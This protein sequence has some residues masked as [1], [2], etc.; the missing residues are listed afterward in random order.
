MLVKISVL[1]L[2]KIHQTY[3]KKKYF[4]LCNLKKEIYINIYRNKKSLSNDTLSKSINVLVNFF[5][6]YIHQ[7][8]WINK[9][10]TIR[11]KKHLNKNIYNIKYKKNNT[12]IEKKKEYFNIRYSSCRVSP[13]DNFWLLSKYTTSNLLRYYKKNSNKY[14]YKSNNNSFIK[15]YKYNLSKLKYSLSDSSY[16]YNSSNFIRDILNC[17]NFKELTNQCKLYLS[18]PLDYKLNTDTFKKNILYN[19]KSQ[20][21]YLKKKIYN[22]SFFISNIYKK[23]HITIKTYKVINKTIHLIHFYKKVIKTLLILFNYILNFENHFYKWKKKSKESY[24]NYSPYQFKRYN[25]EYSF[26]NKKKTIFYIPEIYKWL[27]YYFSK[28]TKRKNFYKK[29]KDFFFFNNKQFLHYNLNKYINP[30]FKNGFVF[31]NDFFNSSTNILNK[32]YYIFGHVKNNRSRYFKYR[33]SYYSF[34]KKSTLINETNTLLKKYN[35]NPYYKHKNKDTYINYINSYLKRHYYKREQVIKKKTLSF[36]NIFNFIEPIKRLTNINIKEYEDVYNINYPN[37][38]KQKYTKIHLF[39]KKNKYVSWYIF[40]R[41]STLNKKLTIY[42]VY[43]L[44]NK[45]RY[46]N[47]HLFFKVFKKKMRSHIFSI[48]FNN[49]FNIRKRR[50][51]IKKNIFEYI[52]I[53]KIGTIY[54]K[55]T[56]KNIFITLVNSKGKVLYSISSGTLGF[57]GWKKTYFLT[58]INLTK[59]F[60]Y[61]INQFSGINNITMYKLV[62][63]GSL[64]NVGNVLKILTKRSFRSDRDL[65]SLMSFIKYYKNYFYNIKK[66]FMKKKEHFALKMGLYIK[67]VSLLHNLVE[68]LINKPTRFDYRIFKILFI[69]IIRNKSFLR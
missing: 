58:A 66:Q 12:S 59:R 21:I 32:I 57:L 24:L 47:M 36:Y 22:L 1:L 10:D 29:F 41:K 18:I 28:K 43:N 26:Y 8:L 7:L 17:N 34:Y 49:V 40:N 23:K 25:N 37:T 20:Y 51:I 2:N 14:Y 16:H 42:K 48:L 54:Y 46:I 50:I 44:R 19:Y 68:Y 5:D 6:K 55:N 67:T 56:Q 13:R 4:R 38:V 45:F 35:T 9:F 64:L 3:N 61:N 15:S 27:M 52:N 30:V 33:K 62:I 11:Y 69:Q 60:I 31:K 53:N 39:G 63:K 65:N